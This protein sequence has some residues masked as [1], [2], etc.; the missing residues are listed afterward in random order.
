MTPV[1]PVSPPTAAPV[2]SPAP[3]TSPQAPQTAPSVP[4]VSPQA[5]PSAPAVEPSAEPQTVPEVAPTAVVPVED[6]PMSA[7]IDFVDIPL[8]SIVPMGI[9]ADG[10]VLTLAPP[11]PIQ[12]IF[13]YKSNL[14]GPVTIPVGPS[15]LIYA[16]V[17]GGATAIGQPTTFYPGTHNMVVRVNG[18]ATAPVRW[19][20]ANYTATITLPTD[21]STICPRTPV[22]TL[23][24]FAGA[25]TTGPVLSANL[26]SYIC[27]LLSVNCSV[28]GR[29]TVDVDD[30]GFRRATLTA[31]VTLGTD[32][33]TFAITGYGMMQR[34]LANISST[35]NAQALFTNAVA[36][37]SSLA[38]VTPA[39]SVPTIEAVYTATPGADNAPY[40]GPRT[41]YTYYRLTGAQIA[42]VVI[43]VVCGVALLIAVAIGLWFASKPARTTSSAHSGGI[44]SSARSD[45]TNGN[46]T[47]DADPADEG[48]TDDEEDDDEDDDSASPSSVEDSE[49]NEESEEEEEEDEESQENESSEVSS[50]SE[51][52]EE[53]S[54]EESS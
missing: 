8:G 17:S 51:S 12:F 45:S 14:T 54:S 33:S 52:S 38:A 22:W 2:T 23:L 16:D 44:A 1:E 27:D 11:Y 36:P 41:P 42:G 25:S 18:F 34:L 31:N 29:V 46:T 24:E 48:S 7:P 32:M 5:T 9:C 40:F 35:P 30:G 37:G 3:E 13:S 21:Q 53:E 4:S 39:A 19:T 47:R 6:A 50:E 43:A 10:N 28:P 20:L 15:N 49:V 26:E